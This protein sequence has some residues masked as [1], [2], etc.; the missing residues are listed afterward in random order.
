MISVA[1]SVA[2]EVDVDYTHVCCSRL[3]LEMESVLMHDV[4]L[5]VRRERSESITEK[6]MLADMTKSLPGYLKDGSCE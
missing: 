2:S 1:A 4:Y 6:L 5:I 3:P